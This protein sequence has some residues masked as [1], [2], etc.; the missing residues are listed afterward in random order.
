VL[1]AAAP[2]EQHPGCTAALGRS[3]STYSLAAAAL[4]LV[5]TPAH[6]TSAPPTAAAPSRTAGPMGTQPS[7]LQASSGQLHAGTKGSAQGAVKGSAQMKPPAPRLVKPSTK[8]AAR[9][10]RA[11]GGGDVDERLHALARTE[12]GS[13][14]RCEGLYNIAS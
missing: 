2:A 12:G 14:V 5:S 9:A 3:G 8:V 10:G 7:L 1:A 11:R 4:G 13:K 6:N